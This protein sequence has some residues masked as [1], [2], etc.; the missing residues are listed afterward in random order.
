LIERDDEVSSRASLFAQLSR[1]IAPASIQEAASYFRLGLEQ[2]D[3]IGSG[4][5]QFMSELLALRRSYVAKSWKKLTSTH[6]QTFANSTFMTKTNFRGWILEER[7]LGHP[8]ADRWR[9][10]HGGMTGTRVL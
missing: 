3:A 1:A 6:Y 10:Y 4:D 2:M 9:N 5:Y 7:W 8:D